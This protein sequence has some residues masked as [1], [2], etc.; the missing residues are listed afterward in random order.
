MNNFVMCL[1]ALLIVVCAVASAN[2]HTYEGMTN[3]NKCPQELQNMI[4]K[5]DN[6]GD[7][8]DVN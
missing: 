7:V 4:N 2:V 1:L 6:V 8:G 5:C 3:T